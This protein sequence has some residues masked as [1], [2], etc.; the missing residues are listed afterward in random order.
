MQDTK[1][2]IRA[3]A[4]GSALVNMIVNPG[5]AWALHRDLRA[6][7]LADFAVDTAVTCVVLS[8]LVALFTT[9]GLRRAIQ[10]GSL[11]VGDGDKRRARLLA[12]LPGSWWALGLSLGAAFAAVLVP[13]GVVSLRLLGVSEL[14]VPW[15]A[16]L[17]ALY[18]GAVAFAVTRWVIARQ[19]H[20]AAA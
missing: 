5:I 20:S 11:R 18:P 14:P 19:L 10:S 17:K 1:A 4:T 12:R 16:A 2:Y 9:L 3:Q 7:P 15:L 13:L 6:V 8:T